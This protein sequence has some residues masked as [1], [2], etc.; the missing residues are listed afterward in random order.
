M[1]MH[2]HSD[3]PSLVDY[4]HN[5]DKAQ[6]PFSD[7]EMQRRQDAVRTI[8]AENSIDAAVF[9]SFHNICYLSGFLYCQ[10]GRNYGL[11]ITHD[12]ATSISAAIDGGQPWR[13]TFG[14]NI[15]YTDWERDNFFQVN[16]PSRRQCA[17]D[18]Y[19]I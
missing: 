4:R 7:A 15:T 3:R 19:R 8:M 9:T 11:V 13:R 18:W 1:N 16:S 12:K 6:F 14:D 17:S 5:G 2:V 10:F